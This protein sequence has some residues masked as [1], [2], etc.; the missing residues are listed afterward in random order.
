MRAM[1]MLLP[2][3]SMAMLL[4]ICAAAGAAPGAVTEGD[5]RK[6]LEV[7]PAARLQYRNLQCQPMRFEQFAEAMR[8]DG[9]GSQIERSAD[10]SSVTATIHRRG[11][12]SCPSPYPP[13]MALP[14]FELRDLNG[15][16]VTSASLAGRPTLIN[17]YFARCVPC[18]LEV[19]PLNTYAASRPDM[20]FLAVTFDAPAEARAFVQR[21]GFRWRVVPDAR[22]F[23]DRMRVKQYPLM[24]LFD[25][26]G[27]LL[28]TKQGGARDELEAAAVLPQ[29]KRWVD[30]LQAAPRSTG[31]VKSTPPGLVR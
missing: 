24:A 10:G 25:A 15:R 13:V 26:D 6:M 18:I 27:R 31:P 16:R 21:F 4:T 17:F 23:I 22:D 30:G 2:G 8:Q 11:G 28:G 20:N 5:F 29:L 3:W 7:A 19:G 1:R 9:V 12:A 14:P